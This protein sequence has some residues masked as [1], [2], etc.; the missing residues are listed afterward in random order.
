MSC[1]R[2]VFVNIHSTKFDRLSVYQQHSVVLSIP[3]FLVNFLYLDSTE[4]YIERY[5]FRYRTVLFNHHEEFV[6]VWSFRGPCLYGRYF[7][8]ERYCTFF[9]RIY[10]NRFISFCYYILFAIDKF[11]WY[12]KIGSCIT[13]TLY[14]DGKAEYSVFVSIVKCGSDTEITNWRFWLWVNEDIPFYTAQTPKVLTF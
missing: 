10:G 2:I 11:V 3:G 14:V 6:K 13:S 9:S 1:S 12:F 5:H 8:V 7:F 4:T